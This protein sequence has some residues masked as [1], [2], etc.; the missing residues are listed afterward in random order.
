MKRVRGCSLIWL[1]VVVA[2]GGA[3]SPVVTAAE[4]AQ[5]PRLLLLL[6]QG[7]NRGEHFEP[8]ATLTA[9]GYDIDVASFEP[10][11]V[12]LSREGKPDEQGRDAHANLAMR[13]VTDI[14]PYLALIL[15]GGYSPANLENDPDAVRIVRAFFDADKP[16][17][18]ICH[19]PR[20][21][22]MAGVLEG[23]IVTAWNEVASEIPDLWRAGRLGTYVDQEVVV[24][25]KL[26]SCRYPNDVGPWLKVL[27]EKLHAYGGLP[28][29]PKRPTVIFLARHLTT[30]HERWMATV[31]T[32]NNG[33]QTR[34]VT[35]A[36]GFEQAAASLDEVD[37][38]VL[39]PGEE[40]TALLDTE[41]G[42]ALVAGLKGKPVHTLSVTDSLALQLRE[43]VAVAV[44]A[45][46]KVAPPAPAIEYTAAIALSPGFDDRVAAV[47]QSFLEYKGHKVA[48]VGHRPGWVRG[49]GGMPLE[50]KGTYSSPPLL[51]TTAVIV[52]PGGVWPMHDPRARQAEQPD[53]IRHQGERDRQRIEWIIARYK[54]GATLIT[55]GFDSLRI[56]RH[57]EFNGVAFAASDQTVWS[58]RRGEGGRYSNEPVLKSAD[59]L[60][61]AKAADALPALMRL[62]DAEPLRATAR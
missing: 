36:K 59:R 22:A 58:F 20:L 44:A 52:A 34:L 24:D 46:D 18:A 43:L 29:I 5:P 49:L 4:R 47:M 55:V 39:T 12:L 32:R 38:L 35:D 54:E 62:L 8:Y 19:G 7:F 48:L 16:V 37:A 56:G 9:L 45:T 42:K 28:P 41:A 25:G 17:G 11:P 51:A 57:A 1:A 61:S 23:R 30:G 10:G 26:V 15:P 2:A 33:V 50:V 53:W 31:A 6:A 13:D 21:L 3:W 27:I 60:Y 40:T 14:S